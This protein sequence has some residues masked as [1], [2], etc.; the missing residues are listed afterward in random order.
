MKISLNRISLFYLTFSAVL[1]I[2]FALY[3]Y[4]TDVSFF[5]AN[6][7]IITAFLLFVPRLFYGQIEFLRFFSLNALAG[8]EIIVTTMISLNHLGAL[9]FYESS[10]YYDMFL[11]FFLP[12]FITLI[13][14][15]IFGADAYLHQKYNLRSIQIKALGLTI[16]LIVFWETF[17]YFGDQ[18][19]G[20]HMYGQT[21]ESYD[22]LYDVLVG[23]SSVLIVYFINQRYLRKIILWITN[24]APTKSV[25]DS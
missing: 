6:V 22:T 9:G 7:G 12:F 5:R 23:I 11:H 4:Q 8:F 13:L 1:Y 25:K 17:E 16:F 2:S 21:G 19:F 3:L 18:I 15:G 14:A 24:S 20:T 10:Q